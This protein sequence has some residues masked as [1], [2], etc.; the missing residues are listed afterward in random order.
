M[1]SDSAA[2]T[3][4]A[5]GADII[6]VENLVAGYGERILL[7]DVSFNVQRGEVFAILGGSGSGKSTLLRH[8][9]GLQEPIGGRVLVDGEDITQ[10]QGERRQAILR[11][12]GVMYQHGAL[13]G[14]MSLLE[15]VALPIEAHT[16]LPP[17]ARDLIARMK[18]KLVGLAQ[19]A[20]YLPSQLSGGMQKR[21]AIARAL[22]LDPHIVF[23]DEPSAGLDPITS[24]E[25]DQLIL[26]LAHRLGLTFV[27]VSHEL[28]SIFT[29][30][31]RA[32]LLDGASRGI[33][34]AGKPQVL[35]QTS[36]NP[37][38]RRFLRREAQTERVDVQAP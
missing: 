28:A 22:A 2:I 25:L 38:V 32:I 33:V 13:F 18:L 15:N 9:I 12:I 5:H 19:F 14:S 26:S 23:L 3:A 8:L 30:A 4:F 36:D 17:D 29:I 21:A 37:W 6:R 31:D 35:A 27:V 34:A 16:A 11:K 20:D 10:A 7:R 24:S 1:A